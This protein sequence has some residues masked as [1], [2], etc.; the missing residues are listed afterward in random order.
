V[1]HRSRFCDCNDL[2]WGNNGNCWR[3]AEHV[4]QSGA[5]TKKNTTQDQVL[6]RIAL[7]SSAEQTEHV[8]LLCLDS[9]RL[10]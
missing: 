4:S 8:P 5:A 1:I 6:H 3:T 7:G 2:H 9:L 10:E